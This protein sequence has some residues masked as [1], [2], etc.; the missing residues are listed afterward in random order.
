MFAADCPQNISP[1]ATFGVTVVISI[2]RRSGSLLTTQ[3]FTAIALINLL[4]A[5]VIQL[6]QLMPQLLQ[7]VGSFERIQEYANYAENGSFHHGSSESSSAANPS[8]ILK[9]LRRT[10]GGDCNKHMIRIRGSSFAWKKPTESFLKDIN[11]EIP[12]GSINIFVGGVGSGKTMLMKSILGETV[13]S[14]GPT[15]SRVSSFAY[16]AQ[17]PWLEHGTIQSNIIGP[18]PYDPAWYKTVIGACQLEADLQSLEK[19]DKTIVGS[20][21]SNLSGGQIQRIVRVPKESDYVQLN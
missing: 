13:C 14:V 16:C 20:K 6:V 5:P 10:R 7:C 8:I 1:L 15:L 17:Q 4:T 12:K 21:G 3:A 18:T 2:F 9:P 19:G 11:L